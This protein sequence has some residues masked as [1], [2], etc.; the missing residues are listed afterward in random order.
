MPNPGGTSAFSLPMPLSSNCD[1]GRSLLDWVA[2]LLARAFESCDLD[3]MVTAFLVVRQAALEGPSVFPSYADWF[4][5]SCP[6]AATGGSLTR[7]P[8]NRRT[9]WVGSVP[10]PALP[11]PEPQLLCLGFAPSS[12]GLLACPVRSPSTGVRSGNQEN[13]CARCSWHSVL[14]PEGGPSPSA[15]SSLCFHH[16]CAAVHGLPSLASEKAS[17]RHQL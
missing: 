17:S 2:R 13:K 1:C 9:L 14:I 8:R 5:V 7:R 16:I 15:G 6:P 3:S 10:L 12:R 11:P 4:Q